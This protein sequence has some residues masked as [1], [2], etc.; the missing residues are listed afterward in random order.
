MRQNV[1]KIERLGS[2]LAGG[3]L[4]AYALRKR[5]AGSVAL[6]T[7]GT[8]L[9]ARAATGFCPAYNA[10]GINKAEDSEAWRNLTPREK[11][12][13]SRQPARTWPLPEGARR[14]R[15]D[16]PEDNIVDEASLESFPASDPPS[17]TPTRVG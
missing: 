1:G 11:T 8:T 2:L 3:A 7:L 9:I 4:V 12:V 5:S 10:L 15:P 14:I 16:E 13:P 17:F 6:G